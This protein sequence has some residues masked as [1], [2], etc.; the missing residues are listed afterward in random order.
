MACSH[1]TGPG[2]GQGTGNDEF[3][4][5]AMYCTKYT[6]TGTGAGMGNHCFLLCPS[7]SL[8]IMGSV[9]ASSNCSSSYL[10]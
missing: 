4:Y 3:L 1:C 6:G 7:L 5:Y 10:L 8:A 9:T 2:L